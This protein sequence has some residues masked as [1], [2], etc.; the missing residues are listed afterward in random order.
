LYSLTVESEFRTHLFRQLTL[1]NRGITN[2]ISL[3][4]C[5]SFLIV[6]YIIFNGQWNVKVMIK[7]Y[8]PINLQYFMPVL[9]PGLNTA[10]SNAFSVGLNRYSLFEWTIMDV[11]DGCDAPHFYSWPKADS[12]PPKRRNNKNPN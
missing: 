12:F 2:F 5:Y 11:N 6:Y 4:A 3:N 9:R 7:I 8:N 10:F 1:L